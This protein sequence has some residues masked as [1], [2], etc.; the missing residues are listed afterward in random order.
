M[1]ALFLTTGGGLDLRPAAPVES[2]TV[3]RTVLSPGNIDIHVRNGS[4]EALTI[5][6][7]IIN[8][9]VWPVSITPN[10]I[11]RL[12]A[13]TIHLDYMWTRGEAY[14]LT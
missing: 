13:A 11:P 10:P 12:S 3:E 14:E 4:P 9:A 7:V 5:S 6:Q 2:L 1:I 8:D